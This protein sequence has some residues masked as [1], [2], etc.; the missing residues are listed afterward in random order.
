MT[1]LFE[2]EEPEMSKTDL[3]DGYAKRL[4]SIYP[5]PRSKLQSVS[6]YREELDEESRCEVATVYPLIN[7]NVTPWF[8][9]SLFYQAV[10]RDS[11]KRAPVGAHQAKIDTE[12]EREEEAEL[13]ELV[14]R[15]A[16]V[17]ETKAVD[18]DSSNKKE[19]VSNAKQWVQ[20]PELDDFTMQ[21]EA[22]A[23]DLVAFMIHPNIENSID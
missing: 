12:E 21:L 16:G 22:G 14:D 13:D 2:N 3:I 23:D 11:I 4:H 1:E 9:K 17:E 8:D 7:D 20:H 18:I 19:I 10:L 15:L 6:V 5:G